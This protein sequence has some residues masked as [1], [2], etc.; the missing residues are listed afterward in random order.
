MKMLCLILILFFAAMDYAWGGAQEEIRMMLE[1]QDAAWN[2]GDLDGFM[3]PYDNTSELVFIG[4]Q[5]PV[6]SSKTMKEGYEA[7]YKTGKSDFG[8]LTFSQLEIEEL[9]PDLARA[10]GK[11]LVE[12][13]QKKLS[14]WFSLIL[15]K[16]PE[17]W[18]IIHDH[19]SSD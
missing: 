2:R 5:G 16:K 11:W 7:R 19:S 4:S 8:K 14:G 1:E 17:G 15:R 12:Q 10:W 9:G 18:R 6:R 13:D 3:K